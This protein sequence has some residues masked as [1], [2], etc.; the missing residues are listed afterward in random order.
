MHFHKGS[1]LKGLGPFL[2][3][4]PLLQSVTLSEVYGSNN[5][6]A[7]FI[8]SPYPSAQEMGNLGQHLAHCSNLLWLDLSDNRLRDGESGEYVRPFECLPKYT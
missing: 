3:Q 1:G 8:G 2:P 4:V 5:D 7:D 6:V